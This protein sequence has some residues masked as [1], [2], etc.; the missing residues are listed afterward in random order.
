MTIGPEPMRR[1]L[2]MLLSRGMRKLGGGG[3]IS[4]SGDW[5]GGNSFFLAARGGC[6]M[7]SRA[8]MNLP[9]PHRLWHLLRTRWLERRSLRRLRATGLKPGDLAIDCGANVGEITARMRASGAT[10]YAFEPNPQ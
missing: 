7:D 8:G 5:R 3:R 9:T 1:I 10:V 6:G 2:R 4:V